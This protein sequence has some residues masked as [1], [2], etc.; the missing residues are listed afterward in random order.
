[1]YLTNEQIQNEL[2]QINQRLDTLEKRDMDFSIEEIS[3][4]RAAKI[5]KLGSATIKREVKAG[6]LKALYYPGSKTL[7]RIR[8][9][10]ADV[11]EYQTFRDIDPQRPDARDIESSE[12]LAKKFFPGK[13]G[14]RKSK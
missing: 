14:K 2:L 3:L 12:D 9:R 5:L 13:K 4:N 7:D 10:V 11:R 6:R 8:F 1:M